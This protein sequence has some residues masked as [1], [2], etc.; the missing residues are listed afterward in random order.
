MAQRDWSINRK[1]S[2]REREKC[3]FW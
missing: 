1:H 2:I 3:W